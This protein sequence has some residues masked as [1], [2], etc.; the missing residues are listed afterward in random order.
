MRWSLSGG[1]EEDSTI[2]QADISEERRDEIMKRE[3]EEGGKGRRD[4]QLMNPEG[5]DGRI[6]A[7]M[8]EYINFVDG[9]R[10]GDGRMHV[11]LL[12]SR[13]CS[14]SAIQPFSFQASTS[15]SRGL[16]PSLSACRLRHW[17][18]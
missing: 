4:D 3:G 1:T 2:N 5:D 13:R 12:G 9:Y 6:D 15:L 11:G 7:V 18:K 8:F 16:S 14:I 10:Y 17:W